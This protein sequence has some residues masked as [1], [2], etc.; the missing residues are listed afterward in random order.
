MEII[1][2]LAFLTSGVTDPTALIVLA[3]FFGLGAWR[4]HRR[5]RRKPWEYDHE[6]DEEQVRARALLEPRPNWEPSEQWHR[7]MAANQR[8]YDWANRERGF[9][10]VIE[11]IKAG[12]RP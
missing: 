9:E 5:V 8:V 1:L 4:F 11:D 3:A 6:I 12:R 7:E 2:L 10:Q